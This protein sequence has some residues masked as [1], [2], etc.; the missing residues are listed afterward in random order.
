MS[1]SSGTLGENRARGS[2]ASV[3]PEWCSG[4]FWV[5]GMGVEQKTSFGSIFRSGEPSRYFPARE[6]ERARRHSSHQYRAASP[7]CHDTS[8]DTAAQYF[9]VPGG[10]EVRLLF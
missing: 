10:C 3:F 4:L 1:D 9:P 7:C 8:G 2:L 5:R 6:G